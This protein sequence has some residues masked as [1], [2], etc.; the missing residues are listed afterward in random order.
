ML[1]FCSM[2]TLKKLGISI[3]LFVLAVVLFSILAP[4]GIAWALFICV[5]GWKVEQFII[6]IANIFF[7]GGFSI[8]NMGCVVLAPF[9]NRYFIHEWS[10]ANF[11]SVKHTISLV[12]AYCWREKTLKEAGLAL[13]YILEFIDPGHGERAIA[14]YE[15][16]LF[17]NNLYNI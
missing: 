4:I 2:K 10:K 13:Y 12:I 8:D 7:S 6:Y 1:P 16:K 11:G 3:I 17:K 15:S 14:D 9:M 5:K